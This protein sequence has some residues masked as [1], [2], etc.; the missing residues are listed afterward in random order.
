ML[1][2]LSFNKSLCEGNWPWLVSPTKPTTCGKRSG[3]TLFVEISH[4]YPWTWSAVNP[5]QT[6]WLPH[7]GDGVGWYR[8]GNH[9]APR[10]V[11]SLLYSESCLPIHF[12]LFRTLD[13]VCQNLWSPFWHLSFSLSSTI[14]DHQSPNPIKSTS[15]MQCKSTTFYHSHCLHASQSQPHNASH[16]SDLFSAW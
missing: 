4:R 8:T 7:N 9:S 15:E 6:T 16:P 2:G 12:Y 5:T 14:T 3:I 13:F 1:I 10:N 11:I